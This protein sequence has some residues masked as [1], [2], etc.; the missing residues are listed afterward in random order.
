MSVGR[1]GDCGYSR[2]R[3]TEVLAC[4]IQSFV[5]ESRKNKTKVRN[6]FAG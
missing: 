2:I 6:I 5:F 3:G 4:G 1:M